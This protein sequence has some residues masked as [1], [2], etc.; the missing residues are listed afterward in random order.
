M[1]MKYCSPGKIHVRI[2]IELSPNIDIG[3]EVYSD[4][5][6]TVISGFLIILLNVNVRH[7]IIYCGITYMYPHYTSQEGS[8]NNIIDR[9]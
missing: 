5:G 6:V 1:N 2:L 4:L 8:R 7:N 9:V 3:Q